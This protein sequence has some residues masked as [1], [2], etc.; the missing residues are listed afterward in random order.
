MKTSA[1]L[2]KAALM[3][4]SNSLVVGVDLPETGVIRAFL[5]FA[6]IVQRGATTRVRPIV[7]ETLV[8]IIDHVGESSTLGL[9]GPA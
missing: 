6:Q 2:D 9:A 8:Q 3:D 1:R 7:E 4:L 5:H